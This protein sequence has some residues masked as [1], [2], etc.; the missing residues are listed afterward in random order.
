MNNRSTKHV[1]LYSLA[2]TFLSIAVNVSAHEGHDRPTSQTK[3]PEVAKIAG[4]GAGDAKSF[5]TTALDGSSVARSVSTSAP[6][7]VA[8]SPDFELIGLVEGNKLTVWLDYVKTNIPV[9]SG[10]IE[11]EIGETKVQPQLAGEVWLATLPADFEAG[12]LAISVTVTTE[13]VTDLLAGEFIQTG[14]E[15]VTASAPE[16]KISPWLWAVAGLIVI[17]SLGAVLRWRTGRSSF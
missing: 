4:A 15:A 17:F 11:I 14:F 16:A 1:F 12:M 7:F 2:I 9:M 13:G 10:S 6:R 8:N 5:S 3:T